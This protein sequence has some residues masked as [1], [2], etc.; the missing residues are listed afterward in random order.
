MAY[1]QRY[2]KRTTDLKHTLMWYVDTYG[3]SLSTV[4]RHRE[5]LDHPRALFMTLMNRRHLPDLRKLRAH[6]KQQ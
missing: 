1:R 5:L 2:Q 3:L 6:V 4:R